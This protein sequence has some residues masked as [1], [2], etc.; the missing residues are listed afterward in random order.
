MYVLF[1]IDKIVELCIFTCVFNV[2]T[3]DNP[4]IGVI[5]QLNTTFSHRPALD[6]SRF[7][8]GGG[9]NLLL[10]VKKTFCGMRALEM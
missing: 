4:R 3:A 6:Y 10:K 1:A 5:A 7:G 9:V 8:W 2:T